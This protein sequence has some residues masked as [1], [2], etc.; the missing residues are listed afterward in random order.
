MDLIWTAS[1]GGFEYGLNVI[2]G[3]FLEL[4]D[5]LAQYAPDLLKNYPEGLWNSLRIDG[6]LYAIPNYQKE[7]TQR[8]FMAR[9]DLLDKYNIDA[10]SMMTREGLLNALQ[11][12]K[13]NE[14]IY[15]LMG[16]GISAYYAG[17]ELNDAGIFRGPGPEF[18]LIDTKNWKVLDFTEND[19]ILE[20]H[21]FS[22]EL[23]LRGFI[24]PDALTIQNT[25]AE[26]KT[27]KYFMQPASYKP[28][29]DADYTNSNGFE[30]VVR[31]LDDA[32]ID[33]T[34]AQATLTSVLKASKNPDRAVMLLNLVNT[35]KDFYNTLIFGLEGQDYNKVGENR[36]ERAQNSYMLPAW[37]M[38]NQFNAY[39]L[40]GQ[41][42]DLWEVTENLNR[43]ARVNPLVGFAF[44]ASSVM[45][46]TANVTSVTN[47]YKDI[48]VNG[49]DDPVR[50]YNEM[51]EKSM[52]AGLDK[53]LKEY[54]RQ[55]DEWA[56]KNGKK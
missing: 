4:D 8:G 7:F 9:K 24:T 22:R 34:S 23:Y 53:I 1:Y 6:K 16:G 40:P 31:A 13:D 51:K 55:L 39:L 41:P 35:D 3:A 17:K 19:P 54:Q 12:I 27:K 47:E 28:G 26:F 36:I 11:I 37:M 21:E 50:V 32:Y 20:Q 10:D 15:P 30:L 42:D 29:A 46:E 56:V 25:T 5:L 49:M 43:T 48:L 44:D 18:R 52:Q 45:T 38:G 2:K 14:K 33:D